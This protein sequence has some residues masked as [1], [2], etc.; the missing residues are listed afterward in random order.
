MTKPS[1]APRADSPH[2][3]LAQEIKEKVDIVDFISQFTKIAGK[4]E[5]QSMAVCPFHDDT[6]ASMS[7]NPKKGFF[8]CHGCQATGTVVQF[9]QRYQGLEFREAVDDLAQKYGFRRV[10]P[11]SEREDEEGQD[12]SLLNTS[13]RNYHFNLTNEAARPAVNYMK[14]RG[15]TVESIRKFM[16][17][18]GLPR[19]GPVRNPPAHLVRAGLISEKGYE[20]MSGRMVFPIRDE[21]GV[22]RSFAGRIVEEGD[23]RPKYMN[24]PETAYFSKSNQLFGLYESRGT[25]A[26]TRRTIVVEGYMDVVML[27]QYGVSNAVAAMGTALSSQ[28]I[29][30]LFRRADEIV[31]CLDPDKAGT[32]GA[33]RAITEAAPV[34]QD[35]QRISVL[36][37]PPGQDPDEFVIQYGAEQFKALVDNAIPAST[38]VIKQKMDGAVMRTSEGRAAFRKEMDDFADLFVSAPHFRRELRESALIQSDLKAMASLSNLAN[39][40]DENAIEE[41]LIRI[42]DRA[43]GLIDR[44][45]K[46]SRAAKSPKP[47]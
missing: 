9:H 18:F 24:G 38:F 12:L 16:I 46:M 2:Y 30:A 22:V 3:L 34:L 15:L 47:Q 33:M 29:E 5:K 14:D 39:I 4:T 44:L 19:S 43:A 32:K 35:N 10:V 21:S 27:H 25:I 20:Y 23:T 17:G 42:Q 11:L 7:I 13:A 8:Y 36:L 41:E 31:L 1:T 37:L 28:N 40:D 26:E 6:D 45:H